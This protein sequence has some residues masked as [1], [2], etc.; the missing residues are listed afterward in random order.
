MPLDDE[1]LTAAREAGARAADAERE[2]DV[3]RAD[4]HHAIRRLQ[5]SGSTMREIASALNLSHQ[6]V[7]Q[8]VDACGG[9]RRW[10]RRNTLKTEMLVCSFCG[11]DQRRSTKLVAGPGIVICDT[12]VE[13]AERIV[14]GHQR[15]AADAADVVAVGPRHAGQCGFCGQNRARVEHLVTTATQPQALPRKSKYGTVAICNRCLLL[16]GE[17]VDQEAR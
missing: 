2:A 5:L 4:Y 6:R 3:A 13:E 1:L 8:I 10:R 16:C 12:C 7:Q 11:T 15:K 17:I 9:G 14:A